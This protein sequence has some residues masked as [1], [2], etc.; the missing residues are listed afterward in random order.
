MQH[1]DTTIYNAI[2]SLGWPLD[3]V[4]RLLLA[5]V[6]G[7]LVGLEREVRGR[8][9]GFRTN[10]LVCVGSAVVMVVSTRFAYYDWPPHPGTFNI[11]LDPARIAYGVMTGVGFLGGGA[12]VKDAGGVRGLTTA[13]GLWCVTAIGLAAGL[14][15]YLFVFLATALV[16]AVLWG[17]QYLE[18][19]LPKTHHRAVTLRRPWETGCVGRTV[20]CLRGLGYHVSDWTFERTPDPR[21]VDIRLAVAFSARHEFDELER[22]LPKGEGCELLAIVAG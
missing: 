17:L 12:I 2:E 16:V 4:A 11:N 1:F 10:L 15:L 8:Q 20:D 3:A 14:G 9:A 21:Y 6:C 19:A 5:A 7:G 22:R 13:A 18:K